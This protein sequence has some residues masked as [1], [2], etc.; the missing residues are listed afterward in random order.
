MLECYVIAMGVEWECVIGRKSFSRGQPLQSMG[1]F[2][3]VGSVLVVTEWSC[4]GGG[5]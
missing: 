2:L 1:Q 4:M 5:L 3:T